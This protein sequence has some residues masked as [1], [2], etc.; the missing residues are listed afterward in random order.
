MKTTL[1]WRDVW[2]RSRRGGEA[3][4]RGASG[5]VE[6]GQ[7]L[8]LVGPSGAGKTTLLQVPGLPPPMFDQL[9]E[10]GVPSPPP[11]RLLPSPPFPFL[12]L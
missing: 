1:T 3:V 8:A 2:A 5:R 7:V 10:L 9:V 11:R 4:L 6:A 12:F